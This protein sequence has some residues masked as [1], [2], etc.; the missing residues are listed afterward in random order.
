MASEVKGV[1]DSFEDASPAVRRL[2]VRIVEPARFEFQPG[3][4]LS[5]RIPGNGASQTGS[6]SIASAPD[7]SNVVEI[8]FKHLGGGAA[9]EYL[10]ACLPG[11]PLELSGPFGRF[12][13][14]LPVSRD[15]LFL[16]TGTGIT[17][18]RSMLQTLFRER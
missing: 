6:Y 12:V 1:V 17:P 14:R 7:P 3:Q 13:L 10:Y 4:Y 2:F 11:T 5:F 15:S 16:A 8:C 18:I 9:A